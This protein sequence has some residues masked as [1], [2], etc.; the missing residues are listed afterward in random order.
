MGKS[1]RAPSRAGQ[2]DTHEERSRT[3]FGP[4][5]RGRE[6]R[7]IGVSIAD[8]LGRAPNPGKGFG[9]AKSR[10]ILAVSP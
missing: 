7:L 10:Q 2:V 3:N 9:A 8:M 4:R 1:G 5:N 6:Q